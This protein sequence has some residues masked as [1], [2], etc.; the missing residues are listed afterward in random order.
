[1]SVKRDQSWAKDT[2]H[3]AGLK[4]AII[5]GCILQKRPTPKHIQ[6]SV[7]S[8][9]YM[10][11]EIKKVR[12]QNNDLFWGEKQQWLYAEPRAT[13]KATWPALFHRGGPSVGERH[14]QGTMSNRLDGGLHGFHQ[15]RNLS[16]FYGSEGLKSETKW[17][18]KYSCLISKVHNL[19]RPSAVKFQ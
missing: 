10:N 2:A 14:I 7:Q 19:T 15:G 13:W 9:H 11:M 18:L 1:M 12:E 3:P 16:F 6:W 5:Y 4:Q 17:S 8:Q